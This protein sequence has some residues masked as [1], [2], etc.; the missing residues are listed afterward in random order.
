MRAVGPD[1]ERPEPSERTDAAK[2]VAGHSVGLRA[3]QPW[4]VRS[5]TPSPATRSCAPSTA[6]S[7]VFPIRPSRPPTPST[8]VAWMA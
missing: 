8:C 7:T 2:P 4:P 6:R 1:G 3:R 5:V